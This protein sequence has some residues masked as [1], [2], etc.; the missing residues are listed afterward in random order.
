MSR[1]IKQKYTK[2]KAIDKQ[3]RCHG[4]CSWCLENRMHKHLKKLF[5]LNKEL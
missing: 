4:N 1:T 5:N 2:N 3:C